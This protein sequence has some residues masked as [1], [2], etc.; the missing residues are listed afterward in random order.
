MKNKFILI[1]MCQ[2]HFYNKKELR[3]CIDT[4]LI[5][6]VLFLGFKPL[7]V[8]D[9]KTLNGFLRQSSLKIKGI[10]LPKKAGGV[11]FDLNECIRKI[12]IKAKKKYNFDDAINKEYFD[13]SKDWLKIPYEEKLKKLNEILYKEIIPKLSLINND[14]SI[15]EIEHNTKVVVR[16][17]SDFIKK[18][19]QKKLLNNDRRFVKAID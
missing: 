9:L 2:N 14:I 10:I 16:T 8:T 11:F 13:L 12:Y 5:D 17:S 4:K 7:L 1:S 6:W 19:R 15:E 18:F 3:F